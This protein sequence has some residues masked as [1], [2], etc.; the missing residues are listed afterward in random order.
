MEKPVDAMS[1]PQPE[2][3]PATR[4]LQAPPAMTIVAS[5][6]ISKDLLRHALSLARLAKES[7]LEGVLLEA[8]ETFI[9]W[10]D[11]YPHLVNPIDDSGDVGVVVTG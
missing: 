10:Q 8:L 9:E 11:A 6:P 1:D 2:P 4:P 7:E 3:K 5:C